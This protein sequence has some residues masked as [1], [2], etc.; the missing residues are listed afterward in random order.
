MT[1]QIPDR[2]RFNRRVHNLFCEPLESYFDDQ[3]PKPKAFAAS[4]TACWRGYVAG[5]SIQ[6]G[7][8]FLEKLDPLCYGWPDT[9]DLQFTVDPASG[10]SVPTLPNY[11]NKVFP[12]SAAPVFADWYSGELH[13]LSLRFC[14]GKLV[15]EC[16]ALQAASVMRV[17]HGHIVASH[18]NPDDTAHG[19]CVGA[20]RSLVTE[21]GHGKSSGSVRPH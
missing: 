2:L 15:S 14:W 20:R 3:H 6:R 8:L 18:P 10:L 9:D 21:D 16:E 19:P 12:H 4:C 7:K 1:T 13:Y 11:L 5:W 17:A